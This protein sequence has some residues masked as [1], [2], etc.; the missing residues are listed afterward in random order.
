MNSGYKSII[1]E[2][3]PNENIVIDRFHIVQLINRAFNKYRVSFMNS[4]KDKNKELY[5][6]LKYYWKNLL[7]SYNK[8]DNGIHKEVKYFKYITTE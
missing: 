5:K 1:R 8:L 6:Q 3:F 4:I 7:I 2:L